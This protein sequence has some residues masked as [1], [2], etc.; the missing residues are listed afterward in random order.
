MT[1]RVLS[2]VR[3]V[4]PSTGMDEVGS[5]VIVDGRIAAIGAG[6][7]DVETPS[8]A[9][10]E[11]CAGLIA[12]P[13]LVDACVH[14]GEPGAEHR[15]TIAS[16]SRAAA[17]GGVTSIIMMPDTDPVIDDV[18]LVDFVQ[19]LARDEAVVRV[20]PAAALTKGLKGEEMTEFGLLLEAGAVW[21]SNGR[22]TV[23][24]PA[25]MRRAMTYARDFG[26]VIAVATQDRR[27]GAGVMNEGLFASWLGLP[28]I[29]REAEII[30]LERD[31]RLAGL[32]GARYHAMSI[33]VPQS[34][35]VIRAAKENGLKVTAGIS[36]NHL[37]L[38]ETDIG[39]YRTFFRLSP[40]LRTEDDRRA[41]VA[42]LAEG[43][44]DIIVS[45]HD[46]QD[47]DTKRLPFADAENGAIG[48]ETMLAA[49]LRL[50][51]AGDVP[52]MRLVD[53]MSTRPA[54]ILGLDAGSLAPGARADIALIDPDYPWVVSKDELIS[55]SKNSPF[56]DAR[57]TGK[58]LQ[59]LVAGVTIHRA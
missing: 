48:L 10:V 4:D 19:R 32:T 36:I 24:N 38:N 12:V 31:L 6:A 41:M 43:V 37:T 58:V 11:D 45:A 18:A 44:I 23:D 20:H 59:T 25:V 22:H 16:A 29:P 28:G 9:E 27:L 51:H 8:G 26:A 50:Y 33:S 13:G 52:L 47:V 42:A 34:A 53:A 14:I 21:L 56:E 15:E 39:E 55:K 3:I 7:V 54:R 35:D 5:I 40:P 49:A 17:R 1:P 30:P 2:N 46:P 57:F